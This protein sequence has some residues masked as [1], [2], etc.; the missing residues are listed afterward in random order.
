MTAY[1][2]ERAEKAEVQ[3]E[4]L[5][6]LMKLRLT[7]LGDQN[8]LT[9]QGR[10]MKIET[11]DQPHASLEKKVKQY[12]ILTEAKLKQRVK[13]LIFIDQRQKPKLIPN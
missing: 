8:P 2:R 5:K 13:K 11:D 4:E 7:A 9:S 10:V 12:P 1:H 6:K 3:N